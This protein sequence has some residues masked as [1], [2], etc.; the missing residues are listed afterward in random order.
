MLSIR[1]SG[2]LGLINDD[3]V[4]P[5]AG[6][7]IHPHRDM[8]VITWVLSDALEHRDSGNGSIIRPGDTRR[9]TAGPGVTCSEFD[10]SA[11]EPVRLLQVWIF[12]G[13]R[14]FAPGYEQGDFTE[15][16]NHGRLRR[17]EVR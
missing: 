4:A 13:R 1:E 6:F 12:S 8:E 9:M 3:L 2:R 5:R 16:D 14:R 15:A 10:P 11:D 7:P 17:R